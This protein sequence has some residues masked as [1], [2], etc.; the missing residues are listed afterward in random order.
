MGAG[1]TLMA[2]DRALR[3][4][5]GLLGDTL[6][7]TVLE[8][9]VRTG[10]AVRLGNALQ[11][12]GAAHMEAGCALHLARLSPQP[13]CS[14]ITDAE[15][16]DGLVA[17]Y[18][19]GQPFP[20]T[21]AQREAVRMSHRH[22][23]LVLAGYAGSGKTTVLKGVCDTQEAI[24]KTPLIITLSGRAAQRASEATGRR[25][26]TVARFLFEEEK[27]NSPLG[28]DRVL[29][30]DEASMLGLVE[31]WRIL[32]R[33]GEASLVLCGDPAQLPPVSP[34]VVFHSLA[35]DPDTRKVVLDRV[36]RQDERTGIP[37]LAEGVRNGV[38]PNLPGFSSAVP[39][40]AFEHCPRADLC[41]Q[42]LKI[43]QEL[44]QG[45]VG[46][47]AMQI[48]A[49]TNQERGKIN[50]FFH[51]RILRRRPNLWPETEHIAEG[52]PVIWTQNDPERGL[53]N[54]ALGRIIRIDGDDILAEIDGVEHQFQPGDRKFLQLAWA[55]SVHKSQG[56]QW[57][58]VIIPVYQSQ[59]V[60]RS[61]IYT[62]LTRAQEQV[63]FIGSFAAIRG[64]VDRRPA[65]EGRRCGFPTWLELAREKQRESR[66]A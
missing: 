29:I 37:K 63:V 10:A 16:L 51:R 48:I 40:V 3:L 39:G 18:E 43:G 58:R 22:R 25:A 52:E 62:A 53:T 8:S 46:R 11:P 24:G 65:A 15:E 59:V 42:I 14:G 34:G 5:E 9:A 33:L 32:R 1:S 61:L 45:G 36:H 27:S 44:S 30:A 7:P 31:F 21:E 57:P 50:G 56:S 54:G 41:D 13:P 55:I 12:A 6:P 4:A 23:L 17:D 26:I 2:G 49:P 66:G 28:S 64:A 35:T 60:D 20:L 38:V 19:A 47:E